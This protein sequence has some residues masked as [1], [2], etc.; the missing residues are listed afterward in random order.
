MWRDPPEP[1]TGLEAHWS[2]VKRVRPVWVEKRSWVMQP[3]A[4]S[5]WLTTLKISPRNCNLKTSPSPPDLGYRGVPV[6]EGIAAEDVAAH[7]AEG[8][9]SVG[10]DDGAVADV[11]AAIGVEGV[12]QALGGGDLQAGGVVIADCRSRRN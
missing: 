5:G 10:I 7:V 4:K 3:D 1:I 11:A 12:H 9:G 8:T 2:G 6:V